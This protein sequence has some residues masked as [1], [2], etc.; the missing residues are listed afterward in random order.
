[1][2]INAK[3]LRD[4]QLK[5]ISAVWL[6]GE[7]VGNTRE[8]LNLHI[9]IHDINSPI[10]HECYPIKD[11]ALMTYIEQIKST[12]TGFNHSYTYGNRI[13]Y[14]FGMNQIDYCVD[15]LIKNPISRQAIIHLWDTRDDLKA[16]FKPCIQTIQFVVRGNKL[17]TTVLYRSNDQL[18][19]YGANMMGIISVAESIVERLSKHPNFK[20]L[21][22]GTLTTLAAS[23]HIY[24]SDKHYVNKFLSSVSA[25]I[26]K[27]VITSA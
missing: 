23:A 14:H 20:G 18:M 25:D 7:D 21:Q 24:H 6:L 27:E 19:A 9:E 3:D 5:A 2:L 11:K 8:L 1:M 13:I 26:Y 4:A 12:S 15:T 16:E 17:Y 22:L 10:L